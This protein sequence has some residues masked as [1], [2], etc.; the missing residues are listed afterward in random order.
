MKNE[1]KPVFTV[2]QFPGGYGKFPY[3]MMRVYHAIY[4]Q[5]PI[6]LIP[7]GVEGDYIKQRGTHLTD[8]PWD[9]FKLPL[10]QRIENQHERLVEVTKWCKHKIETDRK[11]FF[12]WCLV[13]GPQKCYYFEGDDVVF[14][15]QIPW[16]GTLLTQENVIIAM[17]R[18][19]WVE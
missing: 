12:Q 14:S 10:E 18:K 15:D 4:M 17:N 11:K 9:E 13:E 16:G 5:V 1:N 3:I 19:H 6:H 7:E 8:V 2:S